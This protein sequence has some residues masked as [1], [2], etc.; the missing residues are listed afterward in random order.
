MKTIPLRTLIER[1]RL[2]LKA[3]H[4]KSRDRIRY[5]LKALL[6]ARELKREIRQ[7]KEIRRERKA[8]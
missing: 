7:D 5:R 4:P 2:A 8:A 6:V 1:Q 3:A